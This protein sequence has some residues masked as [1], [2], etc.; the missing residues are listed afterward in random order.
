MKL[1]TTNEFKKYYDLNK[2]LLENKV[3]TMFF[4]KNKNLFNHRFQKSKTQ[5][6]NRKYKDYLNLPMIS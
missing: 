6:K 3:K 2:Q 4:L 5:S 1:E